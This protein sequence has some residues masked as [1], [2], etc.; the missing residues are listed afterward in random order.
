LGDLLSAIE[1]R[2]TEA[3][4]YY[5]EALAI[6]K[7]MEAENP[8]LYVGNIIWTNVCLAKLLY[9]DKTRWP[10]VENICKYSLE[11]C[12]GIDAEHKGF[13]I[14]ECAAECHKILTGIAE[15]V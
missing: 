10:E 1:G 7:K 14:D 3:E 13:F 8:G 4:D 11:L 12:S 15:S 2:G 9:K 6:R 5:R